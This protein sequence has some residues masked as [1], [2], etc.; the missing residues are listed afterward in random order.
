MVLTFVASLPLRVCMDF[1]SASYYFTLN[2]QFNPFCIISNH[3]YHHDGNDLLLVYECI[4]YF[5]EKFR[6]SHQ[7]VSSSLLPL[8]FQD[9]LFQC[10][11]F[12]LSSCFPFCY[13]ES[14]RFVSLCDKGS[15]N[16]AIVSSCPLDNADLSKFTLIFSKK[17]LFLFSSFYYIYKHFYAF[18]M[19][20]TE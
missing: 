19:Q 1:A 14:S 11:S 8:V 10:S 9:S 17:I 15:I 5:T 13:R 7:P 18:K 20:V 6:K 3:Q 12:Y 4:L 2:V 16:L